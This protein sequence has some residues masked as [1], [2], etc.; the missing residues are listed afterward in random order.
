M[1]IQQFLSLNFTLTSVAIIALIS[2]MSILGLVVFRSLIGESRIKELHDVAGHYLTVV[3]SI[4]AVTLGLIVFDSLES[5][6][7]ANITVK[8]EAKSLS[9]VHSLS[10]RFS[11]DD[12]RQIQDLIHGYV[13]AV[14]ASEWQMMTEGKACPLSRKL[15]HDLIHE[16][17]TV[18]PTTAAQLAILPLMTSEAISAMDSARQRLQES[19]DGIPGIE[20]FCLL[21]GGFVTLFFTYFFTTNQTIQIAMLM[22]ISAV[23]GTNLIL[24]MAFGQ[25][26]SGMFHVSD[27][28]FRQLKQHI[29]EQHEA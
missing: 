19:E 8:N 24:V 22:M 21:L 27:G 12:R 15:M 7:K 14:I 25:P 4:Y 28:E 23:I 3:S 11:S 6:E 9:A 1:D 13:S 29:E 10:E 26:Y 18:E 2:F 16:I 17:N 5:Y 20:W